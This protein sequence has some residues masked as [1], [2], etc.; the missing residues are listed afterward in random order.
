MDILNALTSLTPVITEVAKGICN[1]MNS[2][3]IN[4]NNVMTTIDG[5]NVMIKN[6]SNPVLVEK[7]KP[8]VVRVKDTSTIN[9]NLHIYLHPSGDKDKYIEY[10]K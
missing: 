10:Y 5:K 6:S 9:V 4:P 1:N 3:E 2:R 7:D 8:R